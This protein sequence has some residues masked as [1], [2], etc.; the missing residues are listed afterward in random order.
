[1]RIYPNG[2]SPS[3]WQLEA[4]DSKE[5]RSSIPTAPRPT[6]D[7]LGS[8]GRLR[9]RFKKP[10]LVAWR[11]LPGRSLAKFGCEDGCCCWLP[12]GYYLLLLL[13][14]IAAIRHRWLLLLPFTAGYCLLLLLPVAAIR[15]ICCFQVFCLS[16]PC[17]RRHAAQRGA[18]SSPTSSRRDFEKRWCPCKGPPR[19]QRFDSGAA[20]GWRRRRQ[21]QKQK[22]K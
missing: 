17:P 13:L 11:P 12:V 5:V 3:I 22:Q 19:P 9:P 8:S 10:G 15:Q 16:A 1:M 2:N 6:L 7:T 21:K 14:L 18:H 20:R 4:V